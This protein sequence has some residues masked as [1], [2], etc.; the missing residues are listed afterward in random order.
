MAKLPKGHCAIAP[1]NYLRCWNRRGIWWKSVDMIMGTSLTLVFVNI[2]YS[3]PRGAIASQSPKKPLPV[4]KE[5][6]SMSE[7]VAKQQ[8]TTPGPSSSPIQPWS[9]EREADRLMDDLFSDLDG[10]L[11][12]ANQLPTEPAKPDYVSLKPVA[13]PSLDLTPSSVTEEIFTESASPPAPPPV[14][15][16]KTPPAT[17]KR[18]IGRYLDKILFGVA[19]TSFLAVLGWLIVEGKIDIQ[20]FL[21][22]S[23]PSSSLPQDAVAT[24]SEVDP[25]FVNYM[26]RSLELIENQPQ[27][28]QALPAAPGTVDPVTGN[29]T[30]PQV[31]WVPYPVYLP[32]NPGG[33][34]TASSLL[35]PPPTANPNPAPQAS[36][37]TE[38]QAPPQPQASPSPANPPQ[39]PET[40]PTVAP[41]PSKLHTLVGVIELGDG[42]TAAL[43]KIDNTTQRIGEGEPIGNSGWTL[44][45][46]AN[47][48]AVVRRNGEVRSVY[49]GQE[50]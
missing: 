5:A 19:F 27:T 10:L 36:P 11:D 16:P 39:T 48:N 31:Q 21:P 50:F 32:S 42:S 47:Q 26:L 43:F 28:G 9:V 41:L 35:P 1:V 37:Q 23:D 4:T 22:Q 25:E 38:T 44:V 17:K 49:V 45:S 13:I 7:S 8:R 15:A 2:E 12:G 29:P 34:S 14:P 18:G 24:S 40:S 33:N 30:A 46:A 20:R 3:P 6:I